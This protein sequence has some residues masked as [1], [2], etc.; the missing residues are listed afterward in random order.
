MRTLTKR[1]IIESI[2]G[3]A[4]SEPVRYERYYINDNLRIQKKGHIYQK[5]VLD[6]QNDI[7]EKEIITKDEFSKIKEKARSEIIRDSYLY[8]ND[9]RISIKRYYGKYRGLVR[10]EVSFSSADEEK[11]YVKEDWMGEEITQTALAF[12]KDLSKL[13]RGE[14]RQEL[15]KFL[16]S[17]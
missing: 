12:D 6:N 10:A 9:K 5:E 3:L 11:G 7:L 13:S 4:L 17:S 2:S 14:F 16:R 1:Y 8:L 15:G